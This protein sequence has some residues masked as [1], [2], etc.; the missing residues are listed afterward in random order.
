MFLFSQN[1]NLV[2][3]YSGGVKGLVNGQV[4]S[5]RFDYPAG[6]CADRFGNIYVAEEDSN[7]I[8]KINTVTGQVTTYAGMCKSGYRD[9]PADSALFHTPSNLCADDSGNIYVTDYWNHRIRKI[10][11]GRMVTTVAGS[12]M[13]GYFDGP[14]QSARFTCPRGICLDAAGNLYVADSWNHRVRKISASGAVTTWAGGGVDT[15]YLKEG[16]YADGQDT[17]ARFDV[18]CGL[19]IDRSGNIYVADAY[20]HR[21]RKIDPARMVTTLAGSG[22]VGPTQG[23]FANGYFHSARFNLPVNLLV[24]DSS[25]LLVSERYR[26]RKLFFP[27]TLVNTFAGNGTKGFTSG[28]DTVVKVAKTD[29]LAKSGGLVFFCDKSNYALRVV[30]PYSPFGIQGTACSSTVHIYPN[31]SSDKIRISASSGSYPLRILV[32]DVAGRVMLTPEVS[33]ADQVID[34]SGLRPGLYVM[35]LREGLQFSAVRF[36]KL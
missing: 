29:G 30:V 11:A 32:T 6:M 25:T 18:P 33:S 23:G 16:G 13:A 36:I 8:R 22:P 34:I 19:S 17:S 12:G 21:I 28:V 26:V 35:H 2:L 14:A 4:D 3:T 7:C 9:G 10:S 5:A 31:P 1:N 15:V 27:D 24:F 20:N